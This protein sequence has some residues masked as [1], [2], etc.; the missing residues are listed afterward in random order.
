MKET[1]NYEL[2]YIIHPDLESSVDKILDKVKGFIEKR[3]G[4]I[5]YE[6]NWG[7]RKLAYEINKTDVGIYILWYFT[8]PKESVA[9]IEKD[10]RVTEE[11]MRYIV[12]TV[13]EIKKVKKSKKKTEKKAD[14]P[15]KTEK[16]A[17]KKVSEKDRMKT[18][19]EKLGKL[20]GEEDNKKGNQKKEA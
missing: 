1:G 3:D 5:T 10:I 16:K 12:L 14:T 4:K 9:K 17:E 11:I 15:K 18:I 6:E 7:K 13:P 20:L 2:L 19:D 8:T